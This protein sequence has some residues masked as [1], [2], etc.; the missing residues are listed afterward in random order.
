VLL[1]GL[2]Q[3]TRFKIKVQAQEKNGGSLFASAEVVFH[4]LG[5][6]KNPYFV[7]KEFKAAQSRYFA[8][9]IVG[10]VQNYLY[11]EGNLEKHQRN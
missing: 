7:L 1:S 9:I 3:L 5:E 2:D 10:H 4:T 8:R 11:T 6:F